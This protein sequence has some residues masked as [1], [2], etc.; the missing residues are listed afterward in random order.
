[1]TK[2]QKRD[3]FANVRIAHSLLKTAKSEL[4]EL[5]LNLHFEGHET[6]KMLE[7]V[8]KLRV[9]LYQLVTDLERMSD[10][11]LE[12]ERIENKRGKY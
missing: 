8:R 2:Q 10:F 6:S 1:M 7:E 4:Q 5:H 12:W 11:R 9:D 3:Y